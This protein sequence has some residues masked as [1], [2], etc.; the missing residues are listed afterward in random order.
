MFFSLIIRIIN[1]NLLRN[2][3]INGGTW[4][5]VFFVDRCFIFPLTCFSLVTFP[6]N[7]AQIFR[8]NTS[9]YLR[10]IFFHSFYTFEVV[11]HFVAEESLLNKYLTSLFKYN[12]W[13]LNIVAFF[14]A[15]CF[16]LEILGWISNFNLLHSELWKLFH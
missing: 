4:I 2:I 13:D 8:G 9:T 10:N 12:S 15:E 6:G 7:L 14:S 5:K 11:T 16:S 3:Y 1:D